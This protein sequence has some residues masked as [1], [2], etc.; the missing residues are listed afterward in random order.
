VRVW[1]G[2]GGG[3]ERASAHLL[4]GAVRCELQ[5]DGAFVRLHAG[6]AWCSADVAIAQFLLE[7]AGVGRLP[8]RAWCVSCVHVRPCVRACVRSRASHPIPRACMCVRAE[9]GGWTW[10]GTVVHEPNFTRYLQPSPAQRR[11]FKKAFWAKL[12]GGFRSLSFKHA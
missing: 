3:G 6:Q 5:G 12:T 10:K 2:E 1:G 4:T 8:A 7:P 9:K 11:L